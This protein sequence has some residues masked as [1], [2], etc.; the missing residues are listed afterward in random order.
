MVGRYVLIKEYNPAYSY[1]LR[2]ELKKRKILGDRDYS[3]KEA[4]DIIMDMNERGVNDDFF[5]KYFSAWAD[6]PDDSPDYFHL[7]LMI[8]PID[9]DGGP[10]LE[11]ISRLDSEARKRGERIIFAAKDAAKDFYGF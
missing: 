3:W 10:N 6:A 1:W 7:L 2:A 4:Q 9:K 5:E 11:E 8:L